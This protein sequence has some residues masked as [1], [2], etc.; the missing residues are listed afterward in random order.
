MSMER[1]VGPALRFQ[2]MVMSGLIAERHDH[3]KLMRNCSEDMACAADQGFVTSL[4]R[5][6]DRVEGLRIARDAGQVVRSVSNSDEL[7]SEM[8]FS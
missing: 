1:I 2:F 8:L 3:G 4:G 7:F 5:Y 6:V